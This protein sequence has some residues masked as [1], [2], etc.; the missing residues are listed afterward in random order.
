MS[1]PGEDTVGESFEL[2]INAAQKAGTL[3]GTV[4]PIAIS[5]GSVPEKLNF[6]HLR[7]SSASSYFSVCAFT[8]R[9]K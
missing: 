4:G 2:N 6:D 8:I 3:T 7:T 5:Q 9:L 1:I